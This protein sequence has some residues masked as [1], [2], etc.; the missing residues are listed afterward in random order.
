MYR[1]L[2]S[3]FK[4]ELNLKC[5]KFTFFFLIF[6]AFDSVM[7]VLGARA[8]S[9]CAN[10]LLFNILPWSGKKKYNEVLSAIYKFSN[11]VILKRRAHLLAKKSEDANSDNESDNKI[12]FVDS[13]LQGDIDGEPFGNDAILDQVNTLTFNVSIL[14]FVSHISNR[15]NLNN[16]FYDISGT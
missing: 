10:D 4:K 8:S 1:R 11:G 15:F 2:L 14:Y 7:D 5:F 12:V 13:L 9:W 6:F 16:A 3:K